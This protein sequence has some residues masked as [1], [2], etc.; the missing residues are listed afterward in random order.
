MS[1]ATIHHHFVM[2]CKQEKMTT[3]TTIAC[4]CFAMGCKH[5]KMTTSNIIT[6]RRFNVLLQA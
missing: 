5:E 6:H 3:N 1:N 4:H 2:V